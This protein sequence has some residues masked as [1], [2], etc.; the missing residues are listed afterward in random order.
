L[1]SGGIEGSFSHCLFYKIWQ[2]QRS[3]ST[4]AQDN[5]E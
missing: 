3:V 5:P 4:A 2:E 1:A